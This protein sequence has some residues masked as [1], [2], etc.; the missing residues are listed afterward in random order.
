MFSN[1]DF[2]WHYLVSNSLFRTNKH[3][4]SVSLL[5]K[6]ACVN[7]PWDIMKM[8]HGAIEEKCDSVSHAI[9][10]ISTIPINFYQYDYYNHNHKYHNVHYYNH[11]NDNYYHNHV[12]IFVLFVSPALWWEYWLPTPNAHPADN[13]AKYEEKDAYSNACI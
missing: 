5:Q 6:I 8:N 7:G 2:L 1:L 3:F 12:S 9:T 10:A 11:H 4:V 13:G